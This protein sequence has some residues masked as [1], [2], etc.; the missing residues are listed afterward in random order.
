MII[1]R[2]ARIKYGVVVWLVVAVV[3][4]GVS[5]GAGYLA[6]TWP[7]EKMLVVENKQGLYTPETSDKSL[8]AYLKYAGLS[9]RVEKVVLTYE[10]AQLEEV[11]YARA[12][13]GTQEMML[14]LRVEE[15]VVHLWL[16]YNPKLFGNMLASPERLAADVQA[17]ICLALNPGTMP[18]CMEQAFGYIEW[19]KEEGLPAVILPVTQQSWWRRLVPQAYAACSG[20]IPCG[21]DYV[22]CSCSISGPGTCSYSGQ[23]CGTN[24]GGTCSCLEAIS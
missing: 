12:Q 1:Q 6:A 5:V 9:E 10:P 15:K 19:A 7:G 8:E 21:A 22:D 13:Q 16:Y 23:K 20:T 3:V 18:T 11:A 2:T 14:N 17:G 24:L 4:F